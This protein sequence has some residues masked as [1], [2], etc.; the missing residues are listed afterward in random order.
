MHIYQPILKGDF[1]T[2]LAAQHPGCTPHL[3]QQAWYN[4]NYGFHGCKL[5]HYID[6]RGMYLNYA[7]SYMNNYSF[8]PQVILPA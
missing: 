7:F 2:W 5:Q 1:A 4:G 8:N 6:V 3:L